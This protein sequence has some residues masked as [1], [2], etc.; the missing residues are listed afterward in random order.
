MKQ[1]LLTILLLFLALPCFAGN[2]LQQEYET[3]KMEKAATNP[4]ASLYSKSALF[5]NDY[6]GYLNGW[7]SIFGELKNLQ[8]TLPKNSLDYRY[9]NLAVKQYEMAVK[10][11]NR[12]VFSLKKIII[13]DSDYKL[14]HDETK[15]NIG[16][17]NFIAD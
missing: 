6:L 11:Y 5:E 16:A 3:A 10:T 4:I 2:L 17:F 14:L 1:I 8:A 12:D 13:D 7:N 15:L 9:I